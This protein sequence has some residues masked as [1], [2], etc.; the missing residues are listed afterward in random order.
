[1]SGE[2]GDD[3]QKELVDLFVQEAHEW[4]QNIHVALDELQQGPAP[5]RHQKLVEIISAGV[6]NL[7]GSAATINLPDVEQASFAAL[8]FIDAIRDPQKTV[9]VQD[10]LS[11]CK[12]LG[13]IHAALTKTTGVSFEETDE[14][15]AESIR[16]TMPIPDFVRALQQIQ[17]TQQLTGRNLVQ[18]LIDQMES[19]LRA[20]VDQVD[21]GALHDFLARV[22]DAEEAF[23]RTVQQ[24]L[25][26]LAD[27]VRSLA[28]DGSQKPQ[29]KAVLEASLR[30]VSQLRAD[31]QQVNAAPVMI[32][33][34]G[35]QSLLSVII[36]RRVTLA[37]KR[38]VAVEGRVR[39]MAGI[40]QQWVELGQA[41]RAAI[42]KLLPNTH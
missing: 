11:L 25:P 14:A 7:G 26:A 30:D 20:G 8:P 37:A 2:P 28:T 39:S 4:L 9:S 22:S 21:V 33:L 15:A 5:D 17:H 3:F 32:F 41:E 40:I 31:A 1:M 12:Q 10:F 13:Q 24:S 42:N 18:G 27:K 34:T 19:Q 38:L 35:L 23:L 29:D 6:S 16:Q 36:Q